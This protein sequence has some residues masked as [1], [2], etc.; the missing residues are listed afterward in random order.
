MVLIVV[1]SSPLN[2]D[3]CDEL[4]QGILHLQKDK[5]INKQIYLQIKKE[6]ENKE[7]RQALS[8]SVPKSAFNVSLGLN[9]MAATLVFCFMKKN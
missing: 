4:S 9:F 5:K 8:N 6:Q 3:V 7:L 1:S 2:C